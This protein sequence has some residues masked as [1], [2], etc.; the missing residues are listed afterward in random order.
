VTPY[1]HPRSGDAYIEFLTRGFGATLE[2]R[3]A[4]PEGRVMHAQLRIG[5]AIVELG[6]G[7]FEGLP[8]AGVMYLYVADPDALHARAVAAGAK[9]LSPVTDQ[10]YGDRVG[11]VEDPTGIIWYIARPA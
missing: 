3:H 5:N 2:F 6:D 9:P 10:W 1:F 7:D 4:S 8:R 11:S